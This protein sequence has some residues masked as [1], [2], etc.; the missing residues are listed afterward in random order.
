MLQADHIRLHQSM[1]NTFK[2][3][4]HTVNSINAKRKWSTL[5][6]RSAALAYKIAKANGCTLNWNDWQKEN[7][8]VYKQLR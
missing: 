7:K 6:V 4:T 3:K 1:H 2:G 8:D 5:K